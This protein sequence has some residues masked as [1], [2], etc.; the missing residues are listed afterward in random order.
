MAYPKVYKEIEVGL[1]QV[2]AECDQQNIPLSSELTKKITYKQL[3]SYANDVFMKH[4]SSV[5]LSFW[6]FDKFCYDYFIWFVSCTVVVLTYFVMC[7][8]FYNC[9]GVLVICALV[10]AGFVLF[11][12][13]IFI[14]ICFV[15]TSVR[16]AA[17]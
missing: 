14:L 9:V 16:T 15:C 12:L 1:N 2:S 7:G 13:W 10:F 6:I 8:C 3:N 17:T 4:V 11:R 5:H